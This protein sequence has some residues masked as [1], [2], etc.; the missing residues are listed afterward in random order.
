[1][2]GIIP[3]QLFIGVVVVLVVLGLVAL[4]VR[5]AVRRRSHHKHGGDP[6]RDD[7]TSS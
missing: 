6:P 2:V 5:D 4:V 7:V 1:V 3:I